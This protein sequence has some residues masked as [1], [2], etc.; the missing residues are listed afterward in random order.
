MSILEAIS[1]TARALLAAKDRHKIEE[2][3]EAEVAALDAGK[4]PDCGSE[5]FLEGPHGG[6]NVNI[7]CAGCQ[8]EFNIIPRLAGSFGKERL[9]RPL[10][11]IPAVNH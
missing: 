6:M 9:A 1:P 8:A 11:P 4:C 3:T 10:K 7:Q 5:Q 2:L